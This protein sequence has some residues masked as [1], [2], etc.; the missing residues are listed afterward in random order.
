MGDPLFQDW[1]R[2]HK[3]DDTVARCRVC[4]KT[5]SLSTACRCAV[6]DHGNDAKHKSALGKR[7][8][9]LPPNEKVKKNYNPK[10]LITG[11]SDNQIT[12]N[13]FVTKK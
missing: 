2:K 7:N 12:I 11:F 13:E 9:F 3:N 8:N 5:I 4:S 6:V 10:K 1:L